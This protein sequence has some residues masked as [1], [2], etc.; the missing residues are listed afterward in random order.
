[1]VA[2]KIKPVKGFIQKSKGAEGV[3]RTPHRQA[4]ADVEAIPRWSGLIHSTP[5]GGDV[6]KRFHIAL[7]GTGVDGSQTIP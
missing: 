7:S 2:R 5:D 3:A 1:M 6:E 4:D